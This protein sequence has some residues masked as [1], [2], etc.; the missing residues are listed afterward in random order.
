[1]SGA[2]ANAN[3]P[4]VLIDPPSG[5]FWPLAATR[6]VAEILAGTRT[7]RARWNER[8][9]EVSGL[10]CDPDVA[11]TAFRAAPAPPPR[12]RWPEP[13]AGWRVAVS[14]WAPPAGDPFGEESAELRIGDRPVGW[15]L[16]PE[17]ARA[18]AAGETGPDAADRL[19]AL[20]L[21]VREAEGVAP[22]SIWEAMAANA[23]LLRGDAAEFSGGDALSGVDP[24]VVLGEAGDLRVAAD[25]SVGP[26]TLLDTRDGPIVLDR[27]ARVEAHA[28]LRG[29]LY[30][31]PGS[32]ILGGEVGGSSIGPTCRVRGEVE[33]TIVL[34][35]ANKAH[36]G[37][38]GHSVIGEWVNLGAATVT[39]DLKNTYGS[40][41]VEA[42][43]GRVDTGLLKVGAFLGDHVKTGIGTL[44]ATGA[45]VGVGSHVFGGRGVSPSWLPDFSWH[46]GRGRT[47]V[48]W[49]AFER[50][51]GRAMARRD[52]A[53]ED[54]ERGILAALHAAS[55]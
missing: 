32:V 25:V 5:P 12:N 21:P 47:A 22:G 28:T 29:P 16:G 40:V 8:V 48:R 27:G 10:V 55:A 42:R 41:R 30:V 4:L 52:R 1:V 26:F 38:V 31:G 54:G 39:S 20:G 6:P 2:G 23:E 46:D 50:A 45:R 11:D 18:V 49:D 19:A 13:A 36:D 14:T 53:L 35:F 33:A 17:E 44:L 3:A 9:G 51:A 43:E 34:G 15:R 24:L 37:F 7:F